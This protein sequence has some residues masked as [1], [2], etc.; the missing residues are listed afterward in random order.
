MYSY[1][2]TSTYMYSYNITN[3]S[4][5]YPEN[6][7]NIDAYQ[8]LSS[9]CTFLL[10]VLRWLLWCNSGFAIWSRYFTSCFIFYCKAF[11]CML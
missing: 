7:K 11:I 8:I 1:N 5:V 9:I 2:I 3:P 6:K 10:T 4:P